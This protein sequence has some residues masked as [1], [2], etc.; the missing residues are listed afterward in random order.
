MIDWPIPSFIGELYTNGSRTWEWNGKAWVGYGPT[1]IGPIG[2]TG[3]QGLVGATGATGPNANAI[4]ITYNPTASGLS[5]TNVQAAIDEI[6]KRVL[7]VYTKNTWTS[8]QK[9]SKFTSV[10]G[11]NRQINIA[12]GQI[13]I[14]GFIVEE[15]VR[16]LNVKFEI[17]SFNGA[18]G[19]FGMY[20]VENVAGN[21]LPTTRFF[22]VSYTIN[23]NGIYTFP[24]NIDLQ[25]GV[26]SY[27]FNQSVINGY[28]AFELPDNVFGVK[29][30]M[31]LTTYITGYYKNLIG[32][33]IPNPAPSGL[34]NLLD[35][36]VLA[37]L[38]IFEIQKI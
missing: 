23:A 9:S 12:S 34:A 29:S 21:T 17:T 22:D 26:Y 1:L 30:T 19:Y 7:S 14:V 38:A 35:V 31:G 10:S 28:R 2:P 6:E 3:P 25:P 27:A 13:F 8:F 37:P 11:V 32:L 24:V 15:P 20:N 18:N 16:I 33:G 36:N 5:A 4:D